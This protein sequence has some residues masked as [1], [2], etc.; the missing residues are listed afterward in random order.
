MALDGSDDNSG[1]TPDQPLATLAQAFQLRFVW[2]ERTEILIE[3]GLYSVAETIRL[4]E[5]SAGVYS[6]YGADFTV[7]NEQR[8]IR[9]RCPHRQSPRTWW[10]LSRLKGSI[11]AS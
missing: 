7:R 1:L 9:H 3:S 10:L 4:P 5:T 11:S 2:P 8:A 6:G